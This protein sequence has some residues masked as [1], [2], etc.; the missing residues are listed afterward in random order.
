[1]SHP[2]N[3]PLLPDVPGYSL[4]EELYMG[5]CTA[6]YRAL[7]N[8]DT[9]SRSVAR[10][11]ARPVVIKVLRSP[12]PSPC[13]LVRFRNQYI[14]AQTLTFP[15]IVKPLALESWNH[16]Y[17]LVMEDVGGIALRDYMKTHGCLPVSQVMTI[18]LQLADILHYL[19]QHRVLHKDINPANILIHPDTY[20]I[21]LAD[22]SLASRLP[23]ESLELQSPRSLEGTLAYIAPEQTGRMNRGID[24]RADFYGLGVTLFE[25]LTGE[26]PFQSDNPMVLIHSHIAKVPV[27]PC[28]VSSSPIPK[29]LS[30]IVLKLMAKNA[31]A[32][33]QS[34]L[35]LKHDLQ[36]CI[37][38]WTETETIAEFELGQRDLC[39]RFLIP[40][41]LYGRE[42][43]VQTLM[44]AFERVAQGASE[45]MLISGFSGIGKTA[46]V[47]EIHKPITRQTGYFI[48]GKF[49][50]FNR[51][52]PFSAFVQAFRRLMGQLLS[53]SDLALAD[54]KAKILSALGGQG[55]VLIEVIPELSLI[56]GTQP[57]VSELSGIAAQN[58]FNRL[59]VKFIEIFATL[60]HPLVIFLDDLQWADLASLALLKLLITRAEMGYLLVLGA[61]R[62]NEVSTTHPL[63]LTR[64]ELRQSSTTIH[65]L[66]LAPLKE[67][68]IQQLVAESLHCSVQIAAPLA[69]L[70]Y[71]KTQGNP[72]FATQ[73]LHGLQ[74][75]GWITFNAEAGY[76]Q[77]DLG[78]IRSLA[79]AV[80]VVEFIFRRLQ[81]WPQTTQN[82]LAIAA[83][84][85]SQF[86]LD[87]LAIVCEQ[88]P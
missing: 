66:T 60:E 51:N 83:C 19:S 48:K 40:E 50:Q 82:A 85:G 81:Q 78:Q 18:A 5:E 11:V 20:Q 12:S 31:E 69:Q 86:N 88:S 34:A 79:L 9:Q 29:V 10:S 70:V 15:G 37:D 53:E 59:F 54:W 68:D 87:T 25:L 32:R 27:L 6:V 23:K 42:A 24:Y 2:L 67:E 55:Q 73:F 3:Q 17:A 57:E 64:D 16:S 65:T 71:H 41:K 43:E 26:L 39:D 56:I 84:L 47:N 30:D 1:M 36:T 33:Y 75:D 13:E 7:V 76:W 28:K 61:Y 58:R 14:I 44:A 77:C 52:I 35:G 22:F 21:W 72:F 80:A 49:D 46:V 4:T 74:A 62:D 45:L 63:M 38:Q 8:V